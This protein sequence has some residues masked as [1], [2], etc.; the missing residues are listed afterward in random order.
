MATLPIVEHF[1]VGWLH[2]RGV[3]ELGSS[4][5]MPLF[6]DDRAEIAQGRMAT[7][8]IVEDFNVLK[9]RQLRPPFESD[10]DASP[11]TRL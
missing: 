5:V 8:P 10:R 2:F 3:G 7:L 6:I 9:D 4:S 1:D 11:S